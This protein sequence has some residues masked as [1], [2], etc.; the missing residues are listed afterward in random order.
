MTDSLGNTLESPAYP[1]PLAAL[2]LAP[3]GESM[4]KKTYHKPFL[5]RYGVLRSVVGSTLKWAPRY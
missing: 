4:T 1:A 2:A 5:K 3:V